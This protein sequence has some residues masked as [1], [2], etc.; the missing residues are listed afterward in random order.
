MYF[1]FSFNLYWYTYFYHI[2]LNQKVVT[3]YYHKTETFANIDIVLLNM[4]DREP[5]QNL[6]CAI[7]YSIK[8]ICENK[9]NSQVIHYLM[10]F[11][12][13][14]RSS[15]FDSLK[16]LPPFPKNI[17]YTVNAPHHTRK[18]PGLNHRHF[19]NSISPCCNI[20]SCPSDDFTNDKHLYHKT[21]QNKIELTFP[22]WQN[23][24]T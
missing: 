24:P 15:K 4:K 10:Y 20:S 21:L 16:A 12:A 13:Q 23:L 19:S 2:L 3:N 6:I 1:L 14:Y 11:F 17:W 9:K 8:F 18:S 5:P 7:L 22:K